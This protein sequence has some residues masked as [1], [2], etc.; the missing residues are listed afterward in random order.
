MTL[1]RTSNELTQPNGSSYLTNGAASTVSITR[2]REMAAQ[3]QALRD[4]NTRLR[5]RLHQNG[6]ALRISDQAYRD[7]MLL[8]AEIMADMDASMDTMREVHGV[9][10]RRWEWAR[11]LMRLAGIADTYNRLT[12]FDGATVERK[13]RKAQRQSGQRLDRVEAVS[14]TRALP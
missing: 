13:L 2:Y 4:E 14:T 9:T 8:A 12:E 5:N 11:A 10:R 1:S 6:W 3:M 7:A